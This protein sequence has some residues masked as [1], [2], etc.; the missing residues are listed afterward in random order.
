MKNIVIKNK[1][2]M[3]NEYGNDEGWLYIM[4]LAIIFCIIS[5]QLFE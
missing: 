5:Y 3:S 1:N 2:N 4:A